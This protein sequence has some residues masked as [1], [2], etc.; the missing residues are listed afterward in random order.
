MASIKDSW[1]KLNG[2]RGGSLRTAREC[3]ELTLPH[4]LPPEGHAESAELPTPY[5]SLGARGVNNLSSKMLFA[6]FPTNTA[7]FRLTVNPNLID[8]LGD[9][10]VSDQIEEALRKRENNLLRKVET[11]NLRATLGSTLKHLIVTGNNLIY[12]PKKAPSRNYALNQ[13]VV[14]RDALGTVTK[15][16]IF[17]QAHPNTLPEDVIETCQVIAEGT[18]PHELVDIYTCMQLQK[19]GGYE[20]WQEINEI[21][22]PGSRGTVAKGE[23]PPYIALRWQ[24][25]SGNDYGVGLVEEYLGDLRSLEGLMASV[26][27]FAAAA[28]RIILL[29]HPN[30]TTDETALSEAKSG[31]IVQGNITDLDVLQ[32]D[33][34]ADFKVAKEVVDDLTLRLSHVFLLQSGTVRDAERVTAAEISAMAQELEDVLGGV[35]TVMAQELQLPMVNRLISSE[36]FPK[37]PKVNGE[38]A[39]DPVIVTG[40]EALGRGHELNKL[41]AYIQD[42]IGMVGEASALA[43]LDPDKV[44]AELGKGH[45]VDPELLLKSEE[46]MEEDQ[47]QATQ[48]Q[49]LQTA[50]EKGTGPAIAAAAKN[51]N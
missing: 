28:A 30:S 5:Q 41:R 24:A 21:E 44:A 37:L 23:T 1:E 18:D 39:V 17:E 50:M 48:S 7:F 38:P 34:Y 8:E 6:L 51:T 13:Y 10:K 35:Y 46:Q 26:I 32:L 3:A 45:N 2:D 42:Y 16:V 40:F 29:L 15:I 12:M 36:D 33:K 27:D 43:R 19:T 11:G 49:M 22:V 31:D 20:W 14:T 25:V 9:K 47:Q 4:I